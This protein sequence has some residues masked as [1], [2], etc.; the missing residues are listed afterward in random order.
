M[1]RKIQDGDTCMVDLSILTENEKDRL[2][3]ALALAVFIRAEE[4]RQRFPNGGESAQLSA[5][6]TIFV[7]LE[8]SYRG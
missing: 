4:D 1:K 6:R 3:E 8:P 5:W 7:K 2:Y